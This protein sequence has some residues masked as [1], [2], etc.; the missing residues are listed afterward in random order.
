MIGKSKDASLDRRE[1]RS[2]IARS[3]ERLLSVD[4]I[5]APP[6]RHTRANSESNGCKS[7]KCCS[8]SA[9]MTVSNWSAANGRA[10]ALH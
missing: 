4:T 1:K 8:T 5:K 2:N 6:E 7:G 3:S 10:V 9:H